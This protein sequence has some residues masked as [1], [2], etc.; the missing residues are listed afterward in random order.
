M[1]GSADHGLHVYNTRSGKRTRNLYNKRFGHTDWVTTCAILNDGRVLS[2]SMDKRLCLWDRGAI[3]CKD[4]I[5]HNGSISKVKVDARNVA[6]SSA[7]D[8]SLLVWNLDSL[9]C[10]QGLFK[11]HSDAVLEFEWNNSLCVSGDKKGGVTW[12]DIN[13]GTPVF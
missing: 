12:W 10:S 3:Q 13:T 5:G 7:Y 4:L 6:I 8:S 2:G 11:G 9:E 1:T